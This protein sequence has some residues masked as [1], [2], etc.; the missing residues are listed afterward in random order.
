MAGETSTK[1]AAGAAPRAVLPW[2]ALTLTVLLWSGNFVVGRAVAGRVDPLTLNALRWSIALALWSP[3]FWRA[4]ARQWAAAFG[5]WPR[6]AF[7]GVSG[8]AVFHTCTYRAL[9]TTPVVNALLVLSTTP[10]LILAGSAAL[11]RARLRRRDGLAVLLSV[12]GVAV[13]LAHGD[14]A[15]LARLAFGAGD[16]WMLAAALAW[17][18]YTL[19]LRGLP[20]EVPPALV[21]GVPMVVG[22]AV[23]APMAVVFGRTSPA[24]LD[25]AIWAAVLYVAVGASLVAYLCWNWGVARLGP[26]PAGYFINLMPVF[27]AALAWLAL[28]ETI[29]AGQAA[30][31]AVILSAIVVSNWPDRR[32]APPES[33]A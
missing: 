3:M 29:D 9:Q 24:A 21:L 28:G 19:A 1:G 30:G 17:S 16:L 26:E 4:D 11:G 27:G 12:A 20:G 2:A 5:I 14:I 6:L 13:L 31:A 7:L 22:V 10:L 23:V 18:G 32:P 8:I 33:S 25:G 15:A